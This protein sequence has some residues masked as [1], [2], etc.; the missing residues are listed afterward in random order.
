MIIEQ[1]PSNDLMLWADRE[2]QAE[3]RNDPVVALKTL[4]VTVAP[5]LPDVVLAEVARI[6]SI[7]WQDGRTILKRDFVVSPDDEGLLFGRGVWESTRTVDG[8]PWLWAEHLDRLRATLELL[9]LPFDAKRLPDAEAITQFVRSLTRMDVVLRLNVTAGGRGRPGTV[10]MSATIP[11]APIHEIK[12]QTY[13][14]VVPKGQPYLVWKTF[15]YATRLEV[16]R[17]VSPGFDSTLLHDEN[18]NILEAAHANLFVRL[19][20]GWAT[21]VV[22]GGLLPGTVRR[23]LLERS[24]TAIV[25][26]AIS[27]SELGSVSEA[28]VT[29]SNVGIVPVTRID[30]HQYPVGDETRRL[31]EW[32]KITQ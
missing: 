32:L 18:D 24:P 5:G 13:R 8:V 6:A 1:S 31:N 23:V 22:D 28:F 19:P 15:Q 26:R 14:S 30:D 16:G 10:W 27:R 7:V 21:P 17:Q 29:N 25:E 2:F 20:E 11:P 4:G 9:K 12:L 3:F